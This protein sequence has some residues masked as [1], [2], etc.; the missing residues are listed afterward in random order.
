MGQV[1]SRKERHKTR[2]SIYPALC[3]QVQTDG[4]LLRGRPLGN[5]DDSSGSSHLTLQQA[6]EE[7]SGSLA[8]QERSLE[9]NE[10]F[11]LGQGSA[12][13]ME[14][15]ER[16]QQVALRLSVG[17]SHGSAFLPNPLE[18][19][20]RSTGSEKPSAGDSAPASKSPTSRVWALLTMAVSRV[21]GKLPVP[22]VML[23]G[24]G[25]MANEDG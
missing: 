2:C 19:R 20:C 25:R 23:R 13:S 9:G 14:H 5:A 3:A 24:R 1:F 6:P 18:N 4:A 7:A 22:D 17:F 16:C 8:K 15:A 11:V 10:C 21:S 12:G